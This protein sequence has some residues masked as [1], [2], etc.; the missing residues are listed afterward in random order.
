MSK[1][2]PISTTRTLED[3]A[4]F[5]DI[6]QRAKLARPVEQGRDILESTPAAVIHQ[7]ETDIADKSFAQRCVDAARYQRDRL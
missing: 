7:R 2:I 5:F 4:H 3:A 6:Q 1:P